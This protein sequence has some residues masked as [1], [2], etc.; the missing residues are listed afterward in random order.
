MR[1]KFSTQKFVAIFLIE[2]L[3]LKKMWV[4]TIFKKKYRCM[5]YYIN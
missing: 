1:L 4:I 5:F 2:I 3:N